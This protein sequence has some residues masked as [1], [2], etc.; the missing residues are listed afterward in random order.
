MK[1]LLKVSL[2]II[3]ATLFFASCSDDDDNDEDYVI[4]YSALPST[5]KEFISNHFSDNA[6]T[7]TKQRYV[8]DIDGTY[9]QTYLTGGYEIDFNM[10]GYWVSMESDTKEFPSSLFNTE[11]PLGIK[12]YVEKEY[13]NQRIKEVKKVSVGFEIELSNNLKIS[14]DESGNLIGENWNK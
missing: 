13:P 2:L 14:F 5:A 12:T 10:N 7:S 4:E 11:I 8:P 9:Y 6:V 3:S 1:R